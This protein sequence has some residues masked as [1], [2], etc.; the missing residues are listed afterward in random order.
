MPASGSW[1]AEDLAHGE[2]M[3]R[4]SQPDSRSGTV[5]PRHPSGLGD[6]T[7]VD[8]WRVLWRPE[9]GTFGAVYLA[10]RV[11]QE[12]AGAYAL[13]L[14][15]GRGDARL[16]REAG[17]LERVQHPNVPRL[18]GHGQWYAFP[19]VVMDWV[20]GPGL[21][22][23]ARMGN[24]SR[25][26]VTRLLA[27]VAGALAA[28]HA[29]GGAHRDM[30]GDNVLVRLKDGEPM[31]TDFGA[32]T[33]EGAA[34]LTVQGP[35]GTPLY[36]SPE[37]LRAHLGLA[38]SG[39]L[40]GAGPA[41][42]VYG[43]GVTAFRLLTDSYP[44]LE[45]DEAQRTQERLGGRLPQ[46]PHVLTPG[47]PPELSA[48]VLR[49]LAPQPGQR[50]SARELVLA[51]ESL[52]QRP[53][54][55]AEERLFAWVTEPEQLSPG[56]R[57]RPRMEYEQWLVQARAEEGRA[58]VAAEVARAQA[59]RRA[60]PPPKAEAP[61]PRRKSSARK[62]LQSLPW[63]QVAWSQLVIA[64]LGAGAWGLL[65]RLAH[66][67]PASPAREVAVTQEQA[68]PPPDKP[69]PGTVSM[70]ETALAASSAWTSHS[71]PDAKR[72]LAEQVP[73]KPL[74]GQKRPPCTPRWEVEI[75]GGCWI[76]VGTV[77]APCGDGGHEW[78]GICYR[79]V[80]SE[81]RPSTS[82]QP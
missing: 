52:T 41:D 16:E 28:V 5:G 36:F 23:W 67:P 30:K 8:G 77:K 6:G 44:F 2:R 3:H 10:V 68:P 48:Q 58:R 82:E 1:A 21:Y 56:R 49:M 55:P 17:L 57:L 73:S 46:A 15:R 39:A 11:G 75:N 59:R 22:R 29:V 20:E 26:Q 42:D 34:P 80:Q 53:E 38:P 74:P 13:K 24:P 76:Q 27:K 25:R 65:W 9:L 32:G 7:R 43:L 12:A 51:L 66:Q 81:D 64:V 70:G 4:E 40:S 31:L 35:P 63:R 19:Y 45:V 78:K 18:R 69:E 79:L 72:G 14:A 33:W 37:R 62:H 47:V 50:P 71:P 60:A 54:S 61:R